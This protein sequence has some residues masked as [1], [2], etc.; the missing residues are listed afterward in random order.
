MCLKLKDFGLNIHLRY[1]IPGIVEVPARLCC[2]FL[3]EH[4]G[5]KWSLLATLF[6]GSLMCLLTLTL[7]SGTARPPL[8]DPCS[9]SPVWPTGHP[10]VTLLLPRLVSR[11][12]LAPATGALPSPKESPK[13]ACWK[14]GE[15]GVRPTNHP[16]VEGGGLLPPSQIWWLGVTRGAPTAVSRSPGPCASPAASDGET[17]VVCTF[18]GKDDLHVRSE[19]CM[20]QR[21]KRSRTFS[22]GGLSFPG[23]HRTLQLRTRPGNGGEGEQYFQTFK[24][25][26]DKA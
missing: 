3:L 20:S 4:V 12:E 10:E 11:A 9:C 13:T 21:A 19:K 8:R 2:V 22:R 17:P 18:T 15:D 24:E 26:L 16:R 14:Q 23:R 7:P 1:V 25:P 5:R 6:Q